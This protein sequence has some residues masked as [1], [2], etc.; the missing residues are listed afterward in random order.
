MIPLETIE[1]F[2]Q[3]L[4][5]NELTVEENV[6]GED[7]WSFYDDKKTGTTYCVDGKIFPTKLQA[8]GECER[9]LLI[10]IDGIKNPKPL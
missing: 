9:S 10:L 3:K 8:I 7:I 4:R 6:D 2:L 5:N 1:A